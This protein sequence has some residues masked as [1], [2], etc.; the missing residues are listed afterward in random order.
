M[1]KKENTGPL[2]GNIGEWSEV[3]VLLK[4][5]ADGKLHTADE[6]LNLIKNIF[7]PIIKILRDE[8]TA[9]R[10]AYK[11]EE[12]EISICDNNEKVIMKL[13]LS[14]FVE[15]AKTLLTE[16]KKKH[17]DRTF[18]ISEIE[19]FLKQIEVTRLKAKS[20]QKTD[21]KMVVHDLR[22]GL[23]P[24]LGFSIKSMLG[25]R[26]TLFNASKAT[27]FTYEI[28]GTR[29]M[30]DNE[31][32]QINAIEGY[33]EKIKKIR[34]YGYE[35]IF[36]DIEDKTFKLN[37]MLIDSRLPEI[38]SGILLLK[39]SKINTAQVTKL[40]DLIKKANPIGY[41]LEEKHPFYEYKLKS[42][43]TDAALGMTAAKAWTGKYD[44]TGGII[45]VKKEGDLV[46]YHIYNRDVFQNYLLNNTKL[47][48]PD[49]RCD[50]GKI[51][52]KNNKIYLK[53]NLQIRFN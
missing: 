36:A 26:S 4:L 32:N 50:F 27:N 47:E 16:L 9:L 31:L 15:N 52:R 1:S 43:L 3:Y 10:R 20:S 19:K 34:E 53:L 25:S 38:L 22:T 24:E 2:Q 49:S 7:F 39:Y 23:T 29:K 45:I 44:A 41:D 18:S 48:T 14:V 28:S 12:K 46:C 33:C 21:I 40:I 51:Y 30:V 5:L 13:P 37:L 8:T 6:N 11:I 42:F 35:I 17:Y